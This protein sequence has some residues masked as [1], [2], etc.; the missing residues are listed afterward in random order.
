[1]LICI[2]RFI[3]HVKYIPS[4]YRFNGRVAP[5][6][7]TTV[8]TTTAATKW[9]RKVQSYCQRQSIGIRFRFSLDHV[10]AM[11]NGHGCINVDGSQSIF[12]MD[13]RW[14]FINL[15]YTEKQIDISLFAIA[16]EIK[17]KFLTLL[18]FQNRER[19]RELQKAI[20][21]PKFAKQTI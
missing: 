13:I 7:F 10:V 12:H 17:L 18:H 8:A 9:W 15:F 2:N 3:W 21:H 5:I 20:K 16:F 1:M 14:N 6:C 4:Y 19:E 11:V